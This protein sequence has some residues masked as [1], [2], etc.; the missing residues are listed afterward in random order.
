MGIARVKRLSSCCCDD[1]QAGATPAVEK[2]HVEGVCDEMGFGQSLVRAH[3]FMFLNCDTDV[4]QT[5][6]RY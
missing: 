6:T 3:W 1:V 5:T 2:K 4:V